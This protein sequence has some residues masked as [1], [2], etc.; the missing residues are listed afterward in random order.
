MICDK[1]LSSALKY[2]L[3]EEIKRYLMNGYILLGSCGTV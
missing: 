2:M 1:S 3:K